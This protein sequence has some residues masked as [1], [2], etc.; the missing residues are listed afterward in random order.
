[1]RSGQIANQAAVNVQTLRYYERRGLL[2]APARLESGYR[3]YPSDAIRIVRFVK[4]TQELGFTLAEAESLLALAA[5]GPESCDAAQELA[6]EKI[7]ELEAKIA[8]LRSMKDSLQTLLATCSR[9]RRQREC[10]LL[11]SIETDAM[12][13]SS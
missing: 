9:P 7:G 10:P 1:M 2:Q 13:T 12:A 5:G 11:Q 6:T 3:E 4:R 8:S